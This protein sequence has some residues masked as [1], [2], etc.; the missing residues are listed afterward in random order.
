MSRRDLWKPNCSG[1]G[2]LAFRRSHRLDRRTSNQHILHLTH[3]QPIDWARGP[4]VGLQRDVGDGA[5]RLCTGR[6][7]SANGSEKD[8]FQ[9]D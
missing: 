7:N 9:A 2:R 4:S 1:S 8:S 6:C 5:T 3:S